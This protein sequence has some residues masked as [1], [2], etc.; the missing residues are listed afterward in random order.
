MTAKGRVCKVMKNEQQYFQWDNFCN[1]SEG[2]HF[3]VEA[4]E[5]AFLVDIQKGS[6]WLSQSVAEL[7]VDGEEILPSR[8][9]LQRFEHFL[10]ESSVNA[11]RQEIQRVQSGKGNRGS[12]H[13]EIRGRAGLL[14]TVLYLFGLENTELLFGF[15]SVDYEPTKEYDLHLEE[16]IRQ[17]KKIQ[18]INEL[19]LEGASDY[20]YQ[21]DLVN[22]TCTFSSK[23]LEVLP[24]ESP[25]FPDAMNRVL[26]FIIP[27][28]RQVFL[29]SFTPF[30]T[31]QS[32]RHVAQYRVMTKQGN[33]MWV[34][35]QGKGLHDEEGR[36]LVIAGSL[37]DITERKKQE[38]E[39]ERMLYSDA[40]TGLKNRL[41]FEKEVEPYLNQKDSRG[42]FLYMDIRKFK[43]YNE[44]FGHSF[45]NRVLKEF[46]YMLNLYFPSALGIY[47]FSGDEFLVHL[48]EHKKEEILARMTPFLSN[49][50]KTREIEGNSIYINTY[51]AIV[52]YPEHGRTTEDLMNNA[53]QCLYR[54]SR[55]EKEEVLFYEGQTGEDV[56]QQFRLE[57]EMRK[58]IEHGF[59]HFRV[60]YQPLIRLNEEGHYWM[61]AEALL[62]YSNPAFPNL[63]QMDMIQTLEYSGMILPV[64][65]WVIEQAIHECSRWS[66][67]GGNPVVHVNIAAQQVADAG[68]ARFIK[69]QCLAEGI[70]FSQLVV[71]VTETSLLNNLE[72]AT[73]FCSELKKLGVGVALDDFGTGYSSFNYL[74]SLPLSQIKVDREYTRQLPE[75][76]YNQIIV[77]FLYKLSEDLKLGLCVEGV[78][79]E[80]ELRVLREMG[81][82]LI[83]GFYFERPLEADVFRRKYPHKMNA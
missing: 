22:N 21:L 5:E 1:S 69:E 62:R 43:L 27:E 41:C 59:R 18:A 55:E 57:T 77:S 12:C 47:R 82:A 14:S 83:Q 63:G 25:T 70:D 45:G 52:A 56:S 30:L 6:V 10:S 20:I 19:T 66:L 29:D 80:E 31:G 42:S 72:L 54:M 38:A 26:S 17:L 49:L 16:V 58:D 39:M 4:I 3:P 44:L 74:R 46:S 15:I 48:K 78:E 32:D 11:F 67:A 68:L 13:A 9:S 23:A 73:G 8:I 60:V 53:N 79:T 36:P 24:L 61:G 7:L 76:R 75:N 33:I 64:G 71:E 50:K 51:I 35:C 40:L 2:I 28:D 37:L 34:S 65:R 81:V